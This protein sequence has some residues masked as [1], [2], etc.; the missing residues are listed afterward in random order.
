MRALALALLLGSL[1]HAGTADD[2]TFTIPQDAAHPW[3]AG[4]QICFSRGESDS[5]CGN[6]IRADATQA[7]V[8][9]TEQLSGAMEIKD[10]KPRKKKKARARAPS[11]GDR[12]RIVSGR[13]AKSDVVRDKQGNVTIYVTVLP[14]DNVPKA[15]ARGPS[16]TSTI[17]VPA[18]ETKAVRI[19]AELGLDFDR[20]A[21]STQSD[22][23]AT[24]IRVAMRAGYRV[25]DRLEAIG[26]GSLTT[27]AL[28]KS[29][30]QTARN[31]GLSGRA[32]YA[33]SSP[34]APVR[35][36]VS[37]GAFFRGMMVTGSAFGI[38]NASGPLLFP[39]LEWVLTE[40][41]VLRLGARYSPLFGAFSSLGGNH[42]LAAGARW[43]YSLSSNRAVT[44]AGEY[45]E[46]QVTSSGASGKL[47]SFSIAGGLTW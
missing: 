12:I 18:R 27:F 41:Q 30:D 36:L 15:G 9:I 19:G 14:Q 23:T 20:Y 42:E 16:S 11:I 2:G 5:S 26:E 17:A 22:Y 13:D 29:A 24:Q 7:T 33:V 3:K 8:S 38:R 6:V 47:G 40:K 39:E 32:S 37:G 25:S 21:E 45:R 34:S 4:D 46:L 10:E 28:A 1:A 35:L 31:L 44:V 43:S